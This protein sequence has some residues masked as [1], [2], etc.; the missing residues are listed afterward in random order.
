MH[1]TL[2]LTSLLVAFL[3]AITSVAQKHATNNLSHP[4]AMA[5]FAVMYFTLML[6][7]IGHH[8]EL[9]SSELRNMIPSAILLLFAAVVLNFI[10]N[11]LYF[12]MIKSNGLSL[13]HRPYCGNSSLCC[14]AIIHGSARESL[15]Q[16]HSRYRGGGDWC[17]TNFS[18]GSTMISGPFLA[19][20]LAT[21]FFLSAILISGEPI[22]I[23][24]ALLAA[25]AIAG[26]NQRRP[27]EPSGQHRL[28]S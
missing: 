21:F 26:P 13:H 8:K 25:I 27:P 6:L 10:A 22:K 9:I 16:A 19:E 12:R 23:A 17:C 15:S 28:F 24:A 11:V 1:S 3:W 4:T 20:F 5:I 2:L 14:S 7:Y 18:V